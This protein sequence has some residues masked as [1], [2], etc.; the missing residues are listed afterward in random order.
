VGSAE[1]ASK[2]AKFGT[3]DN[4]HNQKKQPGRKKNKLTTIHMLLITIIRN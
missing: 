2:G 1:A 3:A 4:K